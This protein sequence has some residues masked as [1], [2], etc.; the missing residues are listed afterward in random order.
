MSVTMV[1]CGI[2]SIGVARRRGLGDRI[3]AG[4]TAFAGAVRTVVWC[5]GSCAG[6]PWPN[7]SG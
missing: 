6:M 1:P 3:S 5:A 2:G 7:D 4:T